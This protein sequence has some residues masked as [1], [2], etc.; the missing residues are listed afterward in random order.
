MNGRGTITFQDGST[1]TGIF[2]N[3]MYKGK[4]IPKSMESM[5]ELFE[6]QDKK[7]RKNGKYRKKK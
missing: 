7:N 6:M 3:N 5:M 4:T 2:K 1:W